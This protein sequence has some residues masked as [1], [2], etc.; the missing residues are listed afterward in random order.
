MAGAIL[1]DVSLFDL[2]SS[3]IY[4]SFLNLFLLFPQNCIGL[5]S[6]IEYGIKATWQHHPCSHP[7]NLPHAAHILF[8]LKYISGL[9]HPSNHPVTAL[10]Q[11][12]PLPSELLPQPLGLQ[13]APVCLHRITFRKGLKTPLDVVQLSTLVTFTLQ[14]KEMCSLSK[15]PVRLEDIGLMNTLCI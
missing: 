7:V 15:M 8:L 11:T 6:C 9:F 4:L 14:H 10:N 2:A 1:E 13:P 5:A 12:K 3:V